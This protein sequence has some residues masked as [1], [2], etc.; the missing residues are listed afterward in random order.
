MPRKLENVSEV[1]KLGGYIDWQKTLV[2]AV[3]HYANV[4]WSCSILCHLPNVVNCKRDAF[5]VQQKPFHKQ[6]VFKARFYIKGKFFI[7]FK[8]NPTVSNTKF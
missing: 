6:I 1:L 8:E 2:T 7:L 3:K 4:S 5:N